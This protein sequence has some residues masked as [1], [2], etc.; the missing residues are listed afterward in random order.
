LRTKLTA[1][2]AHRIITQVLAT[3]S[4]IF[5]RA[6]V[7]AYK[8]ASASQK[9]AAAAAGKGPN[10]GRTIEASGLSVEEA[11]KILDVAP[12]KQGK[13]DMTKIMER[14]QRLFDSNEPTKGGSFYLQSKILRARQRIEMEVRVAEEKASKTKEATEGWKPKVYKD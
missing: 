2:Q 1:V 6:V 10:A 7:E 3:G 12:P 14:F 11:C 13:A 8:Q 4:R 9:Y 5:G